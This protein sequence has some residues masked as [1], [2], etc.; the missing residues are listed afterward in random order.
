MVLAL[1]MVVPMLAQDFDLDAKSRKKKSGKKGKVEVVESKNAAKPKKP[2]KYEK[3]FIKDKTCETAS[4]EGGFMTVHKVKGKIYLELPLEYLGREMLIA[5]TVTKSSDA[6]LA[7]I[8]YK[9][10][11]PLH[12]KFTKVDSTIFMNQVTVQPDYNKQDKYMARAV[13]LSGLDPVL[14]SWSMTCWNKDSSAVVFDATALLAGDYAKLAPIKSKSGLISTTA[15]YNGDGRAFEGVKAFKDNVTV[16]SLLSYHVT[17]KA[18]GLLTLKD[19]APVSVGVTRTILLLPEK[20]MRSRMADTRV[21]IFL[22]EK[23]DLDADVD[24]IKNYSVINRWNVQPSDSA[25]WKRG[26]LV[27]PVKPIVFY[28]DDA[29]PELWREPAKKG[30]LRW[31]KAFEAIGL[32]NVLQVKDFP[33]DDPEFDPDNLKY[34]CIR[35]VPSPVANAMGPSWVDPATGEIINASVIVWNDVIKLINNWRF[36]QTSQVDERVRAKRMPADVVDESIEYVIAHEIGHCLGFMHNMSA[37]ASYTVES[38]RDKEFTK[39]NGTT[40]SIMDYA[41]FNYVAQPEDKGVSLTPPYLGVYDYFLVK[42]AYSPIPDTESMKDEVAV[43]EKWVDE[44]A[45]DPLYRYGRQQVSHRY[46]PSAIEEDLGDDPIKAAD[47]GIRNLKYILAHFNEWMPDEVDP[48]ASLKASRYDALTAQYNRYIKAVMLNVGG[49]Y[50]TN[51]KPGTPG[52]IAKPVSKERQQASMKW[53]LNEVRNCDWIEDKSVTSYF[54]MKI[55]LAPVI[56]NNT[57]VELFNTYK[58]VMLSSYLAGNGA[59]AYTLRNWLDDI[60]KDVWNSTVKGVAPSD[61]D[62]ILQNLYV[63]FITKNASAKGSMSK[64]KS[65]ALSGEAYLPSVD[66]I[67]TFG[68]DES[69]FLADNIEFLRSVEE[70]NGIGYIASQM[71]LDK[72]GP[73]GYNWQKTVN[74]RAIDDSKTMFYGEAKRLEK[75]LTKAVS[76]SRGDVRTHY[77]SM[78]YRLQAAMN[79]DK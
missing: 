65:L 4:C 23:V 58:N 27:E 40:S 17:T 7:S 2:S 3:T 42:Y 67:V 1:L 14:N 41:R 59:D 36:T 10:T 57:L 69:G 56:Q 54:P 37:S 39:I 66:H 8:G 15:S 72:Y 24:A 71:S 26:E 5:S 75:L 22:T 19:K 43:L 12:V 78:L 44:K 70:E 73:A 51:V 77:E 33:T 52:D 25:A 6:E 28:L 18:L 32:K 16:K 38:L 29:F 31:N 47:Y 63:T 11:K 34:S 68:L 76:I 35:Y 50:L 79:I 30:V 45:G 48:D 9:P 64:A 55:G 49:I 53:I 62:R 60:Y 21:G 46:D 61:C 13:E 74:T 20:K